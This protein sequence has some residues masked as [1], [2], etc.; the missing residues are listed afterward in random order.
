MPKD[1]LKEVQLRESG[2]SKNGIHYKAANG[3]RMPNYGEKKFEFKM[4]GDGQP[5]GI[6]SITFQVTDATK[7]LAAVSKMVKKGNR[8]V[9]DPQS[10]YIKNI[11]TGRQISLIEVGGSYQM[12]VEY[13]CSDLDF[14]RRD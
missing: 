13:M 6:H 4:T 1:I 3:G 10:S 14:P 12:E 8:V 5:Q 11:Q 7:P 9:F 2:G